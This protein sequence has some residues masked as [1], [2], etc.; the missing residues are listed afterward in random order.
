[1]RDTCFERALDRLPL[2]RRQLLHET[3]QPRVA[4]SRVYGGTGRRSTLVHGAS[5]SLREGHC[6]DLLPGGWGRD[7]IKVVRKRPG[8]EYQEGASEEVRREMEGQ[9]RREHPADVPLALLGGSGTRPRRPESN[10][11]VALK[12]ASQRA[13]DLGEPGSWRRGEELTAHHD[14]SRTATG[15]TARATLL[16]LLLFL[17]AAPPARGLDEIGPEESVSDLLATPP[18]AVRARSGGSCETTPTL[19]AG[20]VRDTDLLRSG[21][22]RDTSRLLPAGERAWR[23]LSTR[24]A[25]LA[26]ECEMMGVLK[27][28]L[29]DDSAQD[30]AEYGIALAV[31]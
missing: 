3:S 29:V 4:R 25:S 6:G 26:Q 7:A 27:R 15:D 22:Q 21:L 16:G 9:R 31:I 14:P 13:D 18:R 17:A 10:P 30:L 12:K 23:L 11:T 8:G 1:H 20:H 28:L 2:G 24:T 19:A 5:R